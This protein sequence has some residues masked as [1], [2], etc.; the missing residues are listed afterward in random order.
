MEVRKDF[1]KRMAALAGDIPRE[2][3]G[4]LLK[5]LLPK[6]PVAVRAPEGGWRS[7]PTTG[8]PQPKGFRTF[9]G[10]RRSVKSGSYIVLNR[11]ALF[12]HRSRRT[13]TY[14]MV[15]SVIKAAEAKEWGVTNVADADAYLKAN[16]PAF[17]DRHID[18]NWLTKDV[19]YVDLEA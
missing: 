11:H 1:D 2:V 3:I 9:K 16:Y 8:E 10:R 5:K 13:W 19:S 15:D 12:N 6:E 17:A 14:A 7:E 18:W 4:A